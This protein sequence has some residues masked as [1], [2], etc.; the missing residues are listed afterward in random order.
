MFSLGNKK[1]I[2]LTTLLSRAMKDM[3]FHD[4]TWME[5]ILFIKYI[6]TYLCSKKGTWIKRLTEVRYQLKSSK[7]AAKF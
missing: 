1:N 4:I 2:F 3:I 7:T 6:K 5:E